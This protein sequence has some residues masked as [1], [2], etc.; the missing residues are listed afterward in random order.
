MSLKSLS[1]A[2][3][4]SAGRKVSVTILVV[5]ILIAAGLAAGVTGAYFALKP[6]SPPGSVHVTDDLGRSVAT[7]Y[8]PSR[9][10]VIAPSVVDSMVAL[11]LRANIVGVDCG[12]TEFGGLTEDYS[13]DQI[14]AWNLTS[15]M[16]VQV[17]PFDVEA[18]LNLTPQLVLTSTIIA[19]QDV[20]EIQ[21][22]Y[23]IPVVVLQ[24]PTLSGILVDD[25]IL[26][27]IFGA[28]SQA[29]ALNAQLSA[30]LYNATAQAANFTSFPTVLL[31]YDA[32]PNG[33]WSYG[34]GT[35]GSSLIEFAS[36]TSISAGSTFQYPELS[37]EQVLAA[38]PQ[39]IVYGT[40]YGLDLSYYASGPFWS[41]FSA[42]QNGNVTGIDSNYFTEP[43]PT[44]ILV[45]LPALIATFHPELT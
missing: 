20:Q 24:P 19:I 4:P 13:P 7:P 23:G 45:G 22:T 27:Q 39:I 11:G 30:A 32:D 37:G 17:Y 9:V 28:A 44:M 40:G 35:F 3:S 36:G 10:V 15:S 42:V 38:N 26:G 18:L 1:P 31:T 21:A 33:Y 16:C 41:S 8:D 43:D 12:P 14:A 25:G 34:P 5:A 2:S 6:A 29:N